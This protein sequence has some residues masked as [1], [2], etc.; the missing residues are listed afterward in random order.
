MS[1]QH[2]EEQQLISL[3]CRQDT[4]KTTLDP[5]A[6]EVLVDLNR[7]GVP[8]IEIISKPHMRSVSL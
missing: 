7:A 1:F 3:S 6:E 8:L 2:G 5:I 4:A